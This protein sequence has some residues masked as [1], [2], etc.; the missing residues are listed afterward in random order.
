MVDIR[1]INAQFKHITSL[2]VLQWPG[3]KRAIDM[4]LC[5]FCLTDCKKNVVGVCCGNCGRGGDISILRQY[6]KIIPAYRMSGVVYTSVC[7]AF[8]PYWGL[9]SYNAKKWKESKPLP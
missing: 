7:I 6:R 1:N 4:E 9:F 2:E 3:S 8:T 5:A